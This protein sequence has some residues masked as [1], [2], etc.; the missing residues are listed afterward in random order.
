MTSEKIIFKLSEPVT[1]R[2]KPGDRDFMIVDNLCMVPRAGFE[3]SKDCPESYAF[4][5]NM[6]IL[7]GWLKPV[8]SMKR[9]EQILNILERS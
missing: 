8:A 6:A 5:I 4:T 7:K 1:V 3:L 9:S 2:V